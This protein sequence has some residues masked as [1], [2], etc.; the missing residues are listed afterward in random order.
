[1]PKSIARIAGSFVEVVNLGK[2]YPGVRAIDGINL[3]F[4]PGEIHSIVGENGAGKSTLVRILAGLEAPTD[5]EIRI[6]HSKVDL[7]KPAVARNAGIHLVP[8]DHATVPALSV[9]RNVLLGH[10]DYLVS[11]S[12]LTADE[13]SQVLKALATVGVHDIDP[14]QPAANL[15]AAEARLCQIAGTLINPGNLLILD[16][17]T[18]VLSDSD[19][20]VLLEKLEALRE[21]GVSILY[22]S[23]RLSEVL[24]LSDKITVLRDGKNVGTFERGELDRAGIIKLMARNQIIESI[25]HSSDNDASEF[26]KERALVVE[27]LSLGR[28]VVNAS[29]EV[30][31]GEVVGI[32]GIQGSGHGLLLDLIAGAYA[33]DGGRILVGEQQVKVG[34]RWSSLRAGI[35]LVPAERRAR[36]IVGPLSVAENLG[37]GFGAEAQRRMWRRLGAEKRAAVAAQLAFDIRTPSVDVHTAKLSGGNQQK[38]VVA[39]VLGSAP[40]VVLLSEPT[41]G[42]DVS[43]KA[44]ILNLVRD[45]ARQ[46]GIAAVLASSEFEELL[47][48]TDRIYVMKQGEI[49]SEFKTRDASYAALLEAAVP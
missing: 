16:E 26:Q 8:Q 39:R 24:R 45:A 36:G 6:E 12:H 47:V 18:A 9:G 5:G 11:Y 22:V 34:S 7:G 49:T 35:R 25:H 4:H 41:Q 32:A 29:F 48:F 42:I 40:N 23:H 21:N 37:I 1:M 19:S 15:S 46:Q 27:G 10:E 2:S 17:P 20:N 33:P 28:S 43:A 13:R 14:D 38:V 31:A 3:K 30:R 44:E